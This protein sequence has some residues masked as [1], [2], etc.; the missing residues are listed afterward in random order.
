M[1]SAFRDPTYPRRVHVR[2]LLWF[3]GAF[4]LSAAVGFGASFAAGTV[5][6]PEVFVGYFLPVMAVLT[7]AGM[8]LA[9]RRRGWT[10][11]DLGLVRGRR[12]PWNLLWQVPLGWLAA[13]I[14]AAA[15]VGALD[16][17]PASTQSEAIATAATRVRPASVVLTLLAV[18][19]VFPLLE[20]ILFRRILLGWI[21]G[22]A[23]WVVGIIGSAICFGLAHVVPA[24]MIVVGAI[25][26]VTA[27]LVRW[28]RSLWASVALH[29][30]NNLMIMLVLLAGL[31]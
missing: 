14:P 4:A 17:G 22:R 26:L 3:V 31:R 9:A 27:I 1:T 12:S 6:E 5:L 10:W 16:M 7:S 19:V 18:A 28:N 8:W 15:V 23:G 24:A 21:E 13:V 2:D 30:A 29:A 20:E 25:G 11:R